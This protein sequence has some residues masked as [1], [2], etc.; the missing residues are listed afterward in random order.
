MLQLARKVPVVVVLFLVSSVCIASAECAWVLW[1]EATSSSLS[2]RTADAGVQGGKSDS[3]ESQSW[4]IL[5]SYTSN[6]VCEK[7]QAWKISQMLALWR[8]QKAEAKV[9]EHTITHE[10]GSNIIQKHSEYGDDTTSNYWNTIRYL[11]LPNTV[12]P[13]GPT[14]R[15]R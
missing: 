15:A 4:N 13:R 7:Q 1:W 2:Y 11:Y 8:K 6:A 3:N 14:G 9:G 5:G 10:S 12:D